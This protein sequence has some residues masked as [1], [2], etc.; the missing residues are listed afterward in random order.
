MADSPKP[1]ITSM[2]IKTSTG[3]MT[4]R[5]GKKGESITMTGSVANKM[6]QSLLPPKPPQDKQ[7]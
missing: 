2:K 3:S 1:R 4:Y 5:K 7:P 6:F